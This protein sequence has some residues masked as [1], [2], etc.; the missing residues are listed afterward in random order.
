MET[1]SK[2]KVIKARERQMETLREVSPWLPR[3]LIDERNTLMAARLAW[4]SRR[5]LNAKTY[6][7]ILAFVGAAHVKGIEKLLSNPQLIT[8]HFIRL[9]LS[10]SEPTLVR[11]VT[12][13]EA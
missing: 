3:V 1:G 11:R 4:I 13:Q 5:N 6:K 10:F 9:D 12:V 2:E 7:K 8:D